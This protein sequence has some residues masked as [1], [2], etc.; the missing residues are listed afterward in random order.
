MEIQGVLWAWDYAKDEA[1]K[2]SE[3]TKEEWAASE[4]AKYDQFSKII[5]TDI[6]YQR[7][8]GDEQP[9]TETKK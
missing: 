2:K 8:Q 3:Q 7:D 5:K 9:E 1:V 4:K 6:F